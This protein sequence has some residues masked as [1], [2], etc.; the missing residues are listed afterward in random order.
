MAAGDLRRGRGAAGGVR[1]KRPE[2]MWLNPSSGARQECQVCGKFQFPVL[3]SCP[4]FPRTNAARERWGWTET[5]DST[6][7]YC[8]CGRCNLE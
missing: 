2:A 1:V 6:C 4:G 5:P 3:H 8:V 7:G